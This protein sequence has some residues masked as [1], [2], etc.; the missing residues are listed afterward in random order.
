MNIIT[1]IESKT[2]KKQTQ[3]NRAKNIDR[4]NKRISFV[5]NDCSKELSTCFFGLTFRRYWC[6]ENFVLLLICCDL[7]EENFVLLSLF[8]IVDGFA[9]FTQFPDILLFASLHPAARVPN[10][11][12]RSAHRYARVVAEGIFTRGVVADDVRQP[13]RH[14]NSLCC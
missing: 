13:S 5:N 2:S 4:R 3:K 11:L 12:T 6:P 1:I 8:F 7:L 14:N 10:L 9:S